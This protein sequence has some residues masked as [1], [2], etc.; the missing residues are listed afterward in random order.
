MALA[1]IAC[2]SRKT[3]Q[4][5]TMSLEINTVLSLTGNDTDCATLEASIEDDSTNGLGLVGCVL[6]RKLAGTL[7]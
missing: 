1:A 2:A 7:R 6:T 4:G 5:T 3:D